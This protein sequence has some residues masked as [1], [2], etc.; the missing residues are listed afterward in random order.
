VLVDGV[1]GC[2]V[3]AF[4]AEVVAVAGV[5]GAAAHEAGF[6]AVINHRYA[7][8]GEQPVCASMKP[9]SDAFMR[10]MSWLS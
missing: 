2:G 8:C 7:A 3:D 5:F 9:S 1:L 10:A 6:R 4:L